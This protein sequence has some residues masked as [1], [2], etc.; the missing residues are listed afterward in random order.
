MLRRQV[1]REHD[2]RGAANI[3]LI[4]T[5][6]R[7]ALDA[8]SHVVLEG[9]L[10]ADRYGTMLRRL[11][12]DHRGRTHVA[13]FDVPFED[14]VAR[15]ATRP[16]ARE[17]TAEQMRGRYVAD[18][19]LGV[20]GETHPCRRQHRGR[21]AATATPLAGRS[22]TAA[23]APS[24]PLRRVPAV[25]RNGGPRRP[26]AIGIVDHMDDP[27]ALFALPA[28]ERD[29]L[30]PFRR[31]LIHHRAAEHSTPENSPAVGHDGLSGARGRAPSGTVHLLTGEWLPACGAGLN[32]WDPRGLQP[33]ADEVTCGRCGGIQR[34]RDPGAGQLRLF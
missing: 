3:G 28:R 22:I 1:L 7:Y 26:G 14:T 23:T 27:P 30:G 2:H 32:G 33:T 25:N 31:R 12:A 24:D 19:Q 15:H 5:V 11:I 4:D 21:T 20:P 29:P 34:S 8:G 16:Q 10:H 9:S 17:F 18:D 13:Y 6:A